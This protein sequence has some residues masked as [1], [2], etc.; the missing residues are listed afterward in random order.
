[1]NKLRNLEI[2]KLIKELD[3]IESD[4]NYKTELLKEMDKE[5]KKNLEII[6]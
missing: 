2:V 3:F 6:I 4:F 1:V 5:F